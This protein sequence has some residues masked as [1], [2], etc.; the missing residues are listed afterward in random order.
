VMFTIMGVFKT[1]SAET[2][3]LKCDAVFLV[4]TM[5][6]SP[7]RHFSALNPVIRLCCW[8]ECFITLRDQGLGT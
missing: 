6:A 2:S 5:R 4:T 1:K 8:H 3:L 7:L